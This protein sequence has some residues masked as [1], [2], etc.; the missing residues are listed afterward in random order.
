MVNIAIFMYSGPITIFSRYQ[1]G[2]VLGVACFDFLKWPRVITRSPMVT[3]IIDPI[4][5][6]VTGSPKSSIPKKTPETGM[7]KRK[8]WRVVAPYLL[9][10]PF[11]MMKP[12]VAVTTV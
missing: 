5:D 10:R 11:Q 7:M 4:R 6:D 2:T 9:I 8:E 12:N 1:E 3:S